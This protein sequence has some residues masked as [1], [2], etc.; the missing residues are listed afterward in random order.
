MTHTSDYIVIGG[1]MI[2]AALAYGLV[3]Q[4]CQ[5][6]MLDEGDIAHRAARGNFG[7]VWV[8]GK[9]VGKPHYA[10][11]T[12]QSSFLWPEFARQLQELTGID[13][14]YHRTGGLD[15]CL[16]VDE[17]E[18]FR[19]DNQ[20]IKDQSDG[21]FSFEILDNRALRELEPEVSTDIP[22]ALYCPMDGH[23]NP[24][25]LL[26]A[27]HTGFQRQ[28]GLYQPGH[29]VNNIKPKGDFFDVETH[30]GKFP[31]A[32]IILA[33]G[34]DNLRLAPM[35]GMQQPVFPV[36]GQILATEKVNPFV[37]HT[38]VYVRQTD[39]GSILMGDSTEYTGFDDGT[40]VHIQAQIAARAIRIFPCLKSIRL[41][42]SWGA[43]RVMTSD[44]L[45]VYEFSKE[46]PGAFAA[47]SHSGVTLAAVNTM[48]VTPQII[49]GRLDDNLRGFSADRLISS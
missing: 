37:R 35:V 11:L 7:L 45:P 1:G 49:T 30:N 17:I 6:I 39:E 10:S 26:K 13:V 46:Y 20:I 4:G 42:R 18:G 15:Y 25:Y 24:L 34:L 38:S 8:Q 22:G 12:R 41:L 43:L 16:T 44:G 31:S 29:R 36:R 9:G 48:K 3:E 27:M 21:S 40:D 14:A 32:K 5:V 28:G 19:H 2:G 33:A 23:A 47:T